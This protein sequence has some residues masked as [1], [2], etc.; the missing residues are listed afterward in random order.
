MKNPGFITDST[1]Q[2]RKRPGTAFAG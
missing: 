2:E 1:D